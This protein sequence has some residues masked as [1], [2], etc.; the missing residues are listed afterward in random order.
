MK[1]LIT[2]VSSGLGHSFCNLSEGELEIYG[3]SRNP[4][5]PEILSYEDF[6][7]MPSPDVLILNSGMGDYGINFENFNESI[8]SEIIIS[9]LIK[10]LSFAAKLYKNSLLDNLKSMIIVGSRFSSQSYINSQSNNGLPGY[11]YCISKVALSL[12]TQM[13]RKENFKFTVNIIHP[14]VLNTQLGNKEGLDTK[15]VANKLLSM[16]KCDAFAKQFDGIYDLSSDR[17]I[18]F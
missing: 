11:G 4:A 1:I 5:S 18:F 6:E 9:N 10:P 8:F 7:N 3:V 14:G 15:D 16:I 17:I 12:F 13:I 2:G